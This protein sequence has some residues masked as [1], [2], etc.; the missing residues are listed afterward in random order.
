MATSADRVD[1]LDLPLITTL[2][3][4][5]KNAGLTQGAGVDA[6]AATSCPYWPNLIGCNTLTCLESASPF[7]LNDSPTLTNVVLMVYRRQH[8]L[9]DPLPIYS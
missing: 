9:N 6:G 3:I 5:A 4:Y 1:A 8:P 2:T 7:I